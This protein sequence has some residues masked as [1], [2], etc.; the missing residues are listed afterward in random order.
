MQKTCVQQSILSAFQ[1]N[2]AD[3]IYKRLRLKFFFN[4]SSSQCCPEPFFIMKNACKVF[5]RYSDGQNT[6]HRMFLP[7]LSHIV[8]TNLHLRPLPPSET[9]DMLMPIHTSIPH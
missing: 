9:K 1:L 6:E 4:S 5:S 7:S 2:A 8:I 3:R